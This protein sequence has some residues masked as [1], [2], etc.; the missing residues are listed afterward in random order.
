MSPENE[1]SSHPFNV[2]E[3]DNTDEWTAV[4]DYRGTP[5]ITEATRSTAA[6]EGTTKDVPPNTGVS[7]KP[8]PSSQPSQSVPMSRI[9][10]NDNKAGMEGL[11]KAKINRIILEA[12]K[13]SKFY[14]NELKKERQVNK[15]VNCMLKTLASITPAQKTAALSAADKELETLERTRDDSHIIV[16]I[17]MDAFYASVE[18]RDDPKLKDIPMAVGGTAML[19][20]LITLMSLFWLMYTQFIYI[21]VFCLVIFIWLV[22]YTLRYCLHIHIVYPLTLQSTSNYVARRYGVRAAMPGF[23]AK[24]LCPNLVIVPLHVSKYQAASELVRDVLVEYDPHFCPV[25]LDESYLDLT[26]FVRLRLG[27]QQGAQQHVSVV[28]STM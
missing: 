26:R 7:L 8:S 1:D 18:I 20:S 24:K 3:D 15:R 25:G 19:V 9:G 12:S 16:H 22:C 17:D 10:L 2:S 6:A 27:Q 5:F 11:D 28:G 14:E 23:I 21:Q 13:G 4:D